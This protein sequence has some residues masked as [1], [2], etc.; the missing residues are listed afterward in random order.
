MIFRRRRRKKWYRRVQDSSVEWGTLP[1]D[2]QE[3]TTLI[4][5]VINGSCSPGEAGKSS[6]EK[7]RE[8]LV[9][10]PSLR[11]N[12]NV[13]KIV[14][15]AL[16]CPRLKVTPMALPSLL[17]EFAPGWLLSDRAMMMKTCVQHRW[18]FWSIDWSLKTDFCFIQEWLSLAPKEAMYL[19]VEF[20]GTFASEPQRSLLV[21][22]I[23]RFVFTREKKA[24][25]IGWVGYV[26]AQ[27]FQKAAFDFHE[28]EKGD[29]WKYRHGILA[30]FRAGL[31]VFPYDLMY[32]CNE[33]MSLWEEI[34]LLVAQ[35]CDPELKKHSFK[36]C[37]L[38][39]R[40]N[41][42]FMEKVVSLDSSLHVMAASELQNDLHWMCF[43][44]ATA[45]KEAIQSSSNTKERQCSVSSR[46]QLLKH[47]DSCRLTYDSY[48]DVILCKQRQLLHFDVPLWN[49]IE[50]YLGAPTS[51]EYRVLGLARQNIETYWPAS[52]LPSE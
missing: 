40:G 7:A 39:L 11:E 17:E 14:I 46:E 27:H 20:A 12:R 37:P 24:D 3:D 15:A 42:V 26:M 28:A 16:S 18:C 2:L 35:H 50:E 51:R 9:A 23:L 21:E 38:R 45:P 22:Q 33:D 19:A 10:T 13:W 8:I 32:F 44:L 6:P 34:Y 1:A 36:K 52:S 31:P 4:S 29:S 43:V 5:W 41:R 25:S 49:L 47:I 48:M 30:W